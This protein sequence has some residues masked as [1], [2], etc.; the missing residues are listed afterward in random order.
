MW[1]LILLKKGYILYFRKKY[2]NPLVS[3]PGW[4]DSAQCQPTLDFRKFFEKSTCFSKIFIKKK[5]YSAQCQPAHRVDSFVF[6]FSFAKYETVRNRALFRDEFQ[7]F[8]ETKKIQKYKKCVSSCFV[9]L[10]KTFRFV[11]LHIFIKIFNLLFK[12]CTFQ[13][14]FA[15]FL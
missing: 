5:F 15:F 13:S 1:I 10:K 8:R 9:K 2:F 12:C 14:S 7:S 4:F 11:F 3:G 6:F